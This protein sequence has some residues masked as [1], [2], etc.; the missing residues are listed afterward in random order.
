MTTTP[1]SPISPISIARIAAIIAAGIIRV[2]EGAM[3]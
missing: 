1:I 2:R 3:A